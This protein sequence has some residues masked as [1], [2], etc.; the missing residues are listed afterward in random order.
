LTISEAADTLGISA[1]TADRYW[2][3]TRAWLQCRIAD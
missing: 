2:A 3:Y 1:A